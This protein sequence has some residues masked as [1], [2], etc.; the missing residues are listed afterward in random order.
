MAGQYLRP[1]LRTRWILLASVL[2]ACVAASAGYAFLAKDAYRAEAVMFIEPASLQESTATG[3]APASAI[4]GLDLLRSER[5]AQRVVESEGLVQEP[6]LRPILLQSIDA[7]RAPVEAMAQYLTEHV[8]VHAGGDGGVVRLGVTL[9]DPALAARVANAYAQAWG[10]VALELHAAAIRQGV[11]RAGQDLASLRA[12]LGA[13]R[14]LRGESGE[15][16]ATGPRA[17]DQF[18]QLSRLTTN[19]T[20]TVASTQA[21]AGG[22]DWSSAARSSSEA[23]EAAPAPASRN[24]TA[25]SVDDEIRVA[26]QSLERAEDRLARLSAEGIGAPFPAHVLRAASIP[27]DSIKPGLATCLE[28]GAGLGLVLALAAAWLAERFDR[29]VRRRSD[30]AK[31]IGV[32]LLGSLPFAGPSALAA[33]RADPALPTPRRA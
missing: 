3:G 30:V 23:G 16:A 10:E 5:V 18:A 19:A 8:S 28:I 14:A 6:S 12:R 25:G 7:R 17:D 4:S 2:L 26:Q 11:E 29:R 21:P 20:A 31:G 22:A 9:T 32:V 33:V 15:F 13:A 27:A 24:G 1:V